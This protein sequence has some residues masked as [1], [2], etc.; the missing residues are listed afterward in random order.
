MLVGSPPFLW[1]YSICFRVRAG[2]LIPSVSVPSNHPHECDHIISWPFQDA[3]PQCKE[4]HYI[5]PAR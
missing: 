3:D 5:G 2:I 4:D 1:L